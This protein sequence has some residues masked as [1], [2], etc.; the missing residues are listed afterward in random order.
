MGKVVKEK[1]SEL[2]WELLPHPPYS[3]DLAP[4][5]HHLFRSLI[6]DLRGKSFQNESDLKRYLQDH[7]NSKSIEFFANGIRDLPRRWQEVI[8]S[9]GKY[10]VKK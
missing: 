10:I 5:D 2:S 7:F 1:L 3:P 8:D 6:N 9:N 4:S